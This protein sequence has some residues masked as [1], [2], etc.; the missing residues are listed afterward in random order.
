LE[1]VT[2]LEQL[3]ELVAVFVITYDVMFADLWLVKP[4]G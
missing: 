4:V 2:T 1:I 3:V